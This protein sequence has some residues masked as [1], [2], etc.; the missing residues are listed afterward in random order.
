MDRMN[1]KIWGIFGE[2]AK[3][4]EFPTTISVENGYDRILITWDDYVLARDEAIEEQYQEY[5]IW[6]GDSAYAG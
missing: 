3:K 5:L 2:N 4:W 1:E 6:K